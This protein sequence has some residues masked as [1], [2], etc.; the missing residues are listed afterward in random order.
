MAIAAA[1]FREAYVT[2]D[3]IAA[4]DFEDFAGRKL[5]YE[6]LWALYENTAYRNIHKW[7]PAYRTVYGLYKY[8]RNIYNPTHRLVEFW[9]MMVWGGLLSDEALEVGAI[10][11]RTK[12]AKV[13]G[14]IATLWAASNFAE[15]KELI[16]MW[17]ACLGDVA[18]KI[19]DDVKNGEMRLEAVHPASLKDVVVDKRGI[20]QTYTIEETRYSEGHE[21]DVLYTETASKVLETVRFETFADGKP[22]PWN[23]VSEAWVE[24]YPFIPLVPIQHNRVGLDYGWAEIHPGRSKAAE[25]DDLASKM[26]DYMRKLFDPIWLF[27]FKKPKN[28]VD[29]T[30]AGAAAT[31]SRPEPGRE[32]MP[33]IYASDS[34]AKAQALVT[35][36]VDIASA[37]A[38]VQDIIAELERD[39][40]ELQMDI[41]TVGGYTTGPAL[42]T[43]RQRVERK[44]IQRRPNYDRALVFAQKLAISIG[45]FRGYAGYETF[46]LESMKGTALNHSIPS[47]RPI[48]TSDA[49]DDLAAK[50]SFW[51]I[52][53][54]AVEKKL[55]LDVV[56]ADLGWSESRIKDFMVKLNAQPK[57]EP[58]PEPEPIDD[59]QGVLTEDGNTASDINNDGVTSSQGERDVQLQ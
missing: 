41:W 53:L 26:N 28:T 15:T 49:S 1:A 57:P 45:G 19:V 4:E 25:I 38:R 37:G 32:E 11:I 39:F 20:V 3:V 23:G 35:N 56:L 47:D 5:R 8:I 33:A 44:V 34:N 24:P 30:G 2:A 22:F 17:G 14:A 31:S 13:R 12:D 48:F 54:A 10:P 42:R 29:L 50:K 51:D 16:P 55:P 6:I 21:K 40:P 9:K 43:A 52:V 18:I 7:A 36:E 46:N 58:E 59:Q 27:N